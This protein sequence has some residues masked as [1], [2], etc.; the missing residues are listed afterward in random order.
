[1]REQPGFRS[2]PSHPW[3]R[4]VFPDTRPRETQRPGEQ[5]SG[6]LHIRIHGAGDN[7]NIRH[8]LDGSGQLY[9]SP[10]LWVTLGKDPWGQGNSEL[11][12]KEGTPLFT[13]QLSFLLLLLILLED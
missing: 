8:N 2:L 10:A 1:M 3:S 11:E 5:H 9:G 4:G 7:L 12:S 6:F 13:E